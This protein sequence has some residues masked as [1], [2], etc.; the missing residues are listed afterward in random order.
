MESK[1]IAWFV[2]GFF[3]ALL[4]ISI[5][6][7]EITGRA[8]FFGK[9]SAPTMINAN[10]CTVDGTCETKDLEVQNNANVLGSISSKGIRNSGI[11]YID[12]SSSYGTAMGILNSNGTGPVFGIGVKPLTDN[13]WFYRG[14]TDMLQIS[15]LGDMMLPRLAVNQTNGPPFVPANPIAYVCVDAKGILFRSQIPCV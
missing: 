10:E 7:A 9:P 8:L 15:E 1:N 11:V 13:L 5:A 6:S 2:A 14:T 3:G 4:L 12:T